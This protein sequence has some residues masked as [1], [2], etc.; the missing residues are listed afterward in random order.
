MDLGS[1]F[2]FIQRY[3]LTH[4]SLCNSGLKFAKYLNFEPEM[5]RGVLRASKSSLMK[6]F[7]ENMYTFFL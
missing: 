5:I 7:C 4:F 6:L 3:L 1:R 2:I